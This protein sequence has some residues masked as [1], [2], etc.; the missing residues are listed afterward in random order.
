MA[1]AIHG[2]GR[3]RHP[4]SSQ[5][6]VIGQPF[7]ARDEALSVACIAILPCFDSSTWRR[8][9]RTLTTPATV[10]MLQSTIGIASIES[11]MLDAIDEAEI[12]ETARAAAILMRSPEERFHNI[13]YLSLSVDNRMG[14][15]MGQIRGIE[16]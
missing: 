2:A 15:I 12:K 14:L 9:S 16:G 6:A 8:E 1:G 3:N 7:V 5:L 10:W 11:G 13:N 4:G